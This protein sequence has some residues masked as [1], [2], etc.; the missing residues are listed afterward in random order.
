METKRTAQGGMVE[1]D[2]AGHRSVTAKGEFRWKNLR[3]PQDVMLV[4]HAHSV[5]RVNS[6]YQLNFRAMDQY[7]EMHNSNLFIGDRNAMAKHH[8]RI[9]RLEESELKDPKKLKEALNKLVGRCIMYSHHKQWVRPIQTS[10]VM[11]LDDYIEAC[12]DAEYA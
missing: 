11:R 2:R 4:L 1:Y 9:L 8:A 6:G 12:T 5:I 10:K 7:G 3:T